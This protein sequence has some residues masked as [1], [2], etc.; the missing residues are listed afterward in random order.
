MNKSTVTVC[1]ACLQATCWQGIFYCND[2]KT[3]G[4][5]EKTRDELRV[6]ALEHP[7]YWGEAAATEQPVELILKDNMHELA[8]NAEKIYA[9]AV[10][11]NMQPVEWASIIAELQANAKEADSNPVLYRDGWECGIQCAIHIIRR[12]VADA[13][14]REAAQPEYAE[15]DVLPIIQEMLRLNY[16]L[17]QCSHAWTVVHKCIGMLRDLRPT[18][19]EVVDLEETAKLIFPAWNRMTKD[20]Q[21][22]R[23]FILK[24][25]A[26]R[27]ELKT[28]EIEGGQ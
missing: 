1:S 6:L 9:D 25:A 20:E 23:L 21:E 5:V 2:Y 24:C 13:P 8:L 22:Y 4:T 16:F 12:H 27:W 11:E 3:A 15:K 7:T 19:R 17:Q 26:Y 18:K 10:K 28:T 14:K